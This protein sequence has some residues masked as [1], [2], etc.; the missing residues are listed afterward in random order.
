MAQAPLPVKDGV[1]PSRVF[2]PPGSWPTLFD[3]LVQRFPYTSPA[4]IQER[5]NR[6]EIVDGSGSPQA[7]RSH[8]Q[9]GR[10]LWYYRDVP[11]ET[12]VP[13]S[14][15]VLYRD[16][17]LLVIDKPHFLAAIPGGRYLRETALTR[18]RAELDL[19]EIS[20][21]HRLDRE[22][23]GVMMLSVDPASRGAY[24]RLFQTREVH[25]EYE[26]IAPWRAD[27]VFPLT[28]ESRLDV[29]ETHF[30]M[31]EVDGP[32]NSRTV[33]EVLA[34]RDGLAWYKLLPHTG[35]KHQLRVHMAALGMPLCNDL[36]Y[37]VLQPQPKFQDYS[38]PLQLL[39]RRIAFTDPLSGK[40]REF[41][42]R[43]DL[44]MNWTIADRTGQPS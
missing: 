42:S 37:P 26:A 16:D 11:P 38:K 2:L 18:L 17:R 41:E 32:A 29:K 24:Q 4:L 23:A 43:L 20:P 19:P 1:A 8:Y 13:F 40:P 36:F 7:A 6:G 27:L 44:S 30:T 31:R 12:P 10:W 35:R 25:K 14:V 39:A 9:P 15:N 33:I 21:L 3:F 28:H 34:V 5:L 22:T